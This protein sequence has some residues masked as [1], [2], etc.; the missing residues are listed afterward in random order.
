M[1][2]LH[3]IRKHDPS[4]A[5]A[6]GWAVFALVFL[7][8][9]TFFAI[10][11]DVR[12]STA[13]IDAGIGFVSLP[14]DPGLQVNTSLSQNYSALP[15]GDE[16]NGQGNLPCLQACHARCCA[17]GCGPAIF[18]EVRGTS[19]LV[20]NPQGENRIAGSLV[21]AGLISGLIRPPNSLPV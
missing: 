11:H 20:A 5:T 10:S 3:V 2:K 1:S 15:G 19:N 6:P 9:L 21:D 13:R 12:A 18:A 17:T 16:N 8:A 14:A 4:Q 7:A